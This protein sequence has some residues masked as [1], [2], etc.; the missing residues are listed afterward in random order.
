MKRCLLILAWT[1][2]SALAFGAP[3]AAARAN[4]PPPTPKKPVVDTY[5][6]TE[7][8]DDYRW[9]EDWAAPA[10]K[11][12]SE[13][14]NACTHEYLDK[15][16][17]RGLLAERFKVL[18]G[19]ASPRFYNL[20]RQGGVLFAM[21]NQP[22]KQQPFLVTLPSVDD[23]G[24]AKV[25]VDPNTLDPRGITAIDWYVPSPDGKLVALSL[26]VGG[27]EDG[28][29]H[30]YEAATGKQVY[31]TIPR[32][33]EGT[34]G[35]SLAWDES[36][37]GFYYTRY[38]RGTERPKED[39][40]FYQQVYHHV[41]GTPGDKD[42][43][44][45]GRDFPR[46]A[47]TDLVRSP[48]GRHIL[49]RVANGDGGEFA[50]YLLGSPGTWVKVAGFEDKATA[51][52][53]G[54]GDELFV[55]SLKGAPRGQVLK[56][57]VK[58]PQIAKAAVVVPESEGVIEGFRPTAT[59]LYVEEMLGGPSRVK[60]FDFAGKALGEVPVPPVSSVGLGPRMGG[61]DL[62]LFSSGYLEP[63]AWFRY[64]AAKGKLERTALVQTS[65]ADFSDTEVVRAQAVSKDGTQVPLVILMK[66][67]IRLDGNN[68]ALLYGYGGFGISMSPYFSAQRRAWI[69]QGGIW[70][71]ASIRGGGEFGE[72]WH[73]AGRLTRK[74][75]CFDDFAA[76][77]EFLVAK[78]YTSPSRLALM[79][80]SNG[81]LL[82]GAEITQHPA[83]FKAVVS[84][85]G[86]YDM[87]RVELSA[88]GA[89]NT[90]EYG[91]VKDPEQFKALY[92]YSPYHRV[93][94]GTAYPAALFLTGAN[95]PRVD[96]MQSRKF[97][98]RLQA[99]N[100]AKTPILLRTNMS[101][102]HGLDMA[103]SERIAEDVDVYS[104]LFYE[105]GVKVKPVEAAKAK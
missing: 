34:G 20:G 91:T 12:W 101:S 11:A 35:G 71:I 37:K 27:S 89:F 46:I 84:Y 88:N 68:P 22:P 23:P 7:V 79:G 44:C 15:L 53:F 105:L 42:T 80:G 52:L 82:M 30:V 98:A 102:G 10:V 66:K 1:L 19:G 56:V 48:D 49:A 6:G 40:N 16:P 90:T 87:L 104:F 41:L 86:I 74:Q 64:D 14:Q 5:H 92:A 21:K 97:V 29:L 47:E 4:C 96:P 62:L 59:R 9:L 94:D 50:F 55:L 83:L 73:D 61:D 70:A 77:A 93:K 8:T 25:V 63:G 60:V 58:E 54:P 38:P 95:D 17:G 78:K 13:A 28:T 75:N 32:A 85:V 24:G 43:Y 33:Q 57:S 45:I 36:G 72:A 67:G 99:A 76:C 65:P 103:L 69:E 81:G 31:E 39:L 26:S 3:S 51:A 18:Q 100:G 2:A